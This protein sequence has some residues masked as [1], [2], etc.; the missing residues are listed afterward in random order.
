M[1]IT[2]TL[3]FF[4]NFIFIFFIFYILSF[5]CSITTIFLSYFFFFSCFLSC[6]LDERV[7]FSNMILAPAGNLGIRKYFLSLLSENFFFFFFL[8]H[9]C[10]TNTTIS[11]IWGSRRDTSQ[12]IF[13]F[14]LGSYFRQTLLNVK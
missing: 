3:H 1:K 4:Y 12:V 10:P 6:V 5:V 9:G 13:Q 2:N 14:C 8:P 11:F 7:S